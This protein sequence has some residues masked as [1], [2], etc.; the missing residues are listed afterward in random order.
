MKKTTLTNIDKSIQSI[1][2]YPGVAAAVFYGITSGS[3]SFM[4]K[5]LYCTFMVI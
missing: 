2:Y 3:M 1:H 4:N 5:V